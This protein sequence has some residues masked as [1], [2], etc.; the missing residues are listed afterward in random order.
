M[1]SHD[2]PHPDDPQGASHKPKGP[3]RR[4]DADTGRHNS[5][6]GGEAL[7]AGLRADLEVDPDGGGDGNGGLPP[8]ISLAAP[9]VRFTDDVA[10]WAQ[11]RGGSARTS[12][13][14]FD[15]F[16]QQI[17]KDTYARTVLATAQSGGAPRLDQPV[18]PA[19]LP[20]VRVDAYR[21]L[22]TAA[23]VFLMANCSTSHDL[24]SSD[25]DE[26]LTV[27]AGKLGPSVTERNIRDAWQRYVNEGGRDKNREPDMLPYFALVRR[28]LQ[29][30]ATIGIDSRFGEPA[31]QYIDSLVCDLILDRKLRNPCLIELIWSYW[32]ERGGLVPTISAISRR[33][34]NVHAAGERDPLAQFATDPLR[35]L[36]NLLWGYVQDAQHRLTVV[37]RSYEYRHEYGLSLGV[38]SDD[39]MRPADNRS[40][41]VNACSRLLQVAARFYRQDDDRMTKADAF[42]VLNAL[43]ETHLILSEGAH[44]QYG[45][46]PWTARMEMLME[47]WLL[48]RSEM[49]EF[50]GRRVMVA[51]PEEWMDRVDTMR[52]LQ[53]W[54][55]ASIMHYWDLAR[56]GEQILLS[57]RFGAW[58]SV[59]DP[60]SAA[61]W[62]RAW[63]AEV[64]SYIHAYRAVTGVD[65]SADPSP[66]PVTV[67]AASPSRQ[68][69]TDRRQARA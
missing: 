32:M 11:I 59:S 39:A 61:N 38:R 46:L 16:M 9:A 47:Q 42:P 60:D 52:Q 4:R 56:F 58:S 26:A 31:E 14:A 57:V 64:Q 15:R 55:G 53:G 7:P 35:P 44:N 17:C 41:F 67:A 3:G 36:N 12:F 63:R 13:A 50:L 48:A 30:S 68:R 69:L 27:I 24:S 20:F 18:S 62:A 33:F 43:R 21:V 5:P 23:E 49:R 29:S 28:R 65:L 10:L 2:D 22:K 40:K 54:G 8:E 1:T 6:T 34:Q 51:Y 45:D 66:M 25:F 37:R 19:P